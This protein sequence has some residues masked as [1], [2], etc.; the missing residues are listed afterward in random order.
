MGCFHPE[1]VILLHLLA[2]Y[3]SNLLTMA[4]F[5]FHLK[6]LLFPEREGQSFFPGHKL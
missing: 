3:I 4:W 5:M 1:S 6:E 2:R